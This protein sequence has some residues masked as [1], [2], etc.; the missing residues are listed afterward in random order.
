MD[1][2]IFDDFFDDFDD[3]ESIKS[4][5]DAYCKALAHCIVKS[6]KL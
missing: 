2:V 5:N 4:M 1:D 6:N 3:E